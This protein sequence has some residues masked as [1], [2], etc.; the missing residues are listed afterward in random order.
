MERDTLS[1]RQLMALLWGALL[2]PAAQLLPGAGG[3]YG[4]RGALMIFAAGGVLALSGCLC[5]ALCRGGLAKGL[6][7]TM[8][9]WLGTALL[10][11]YIIWLEVLL[12]LWLRQSA[13]RLMGAGERDGA[14]WF[15]L[16]VLAGMAL[17]M[18]RRELGTLGRTAQIL[19]CALVVC[20]GGVLL[21]ALGQ[22]RSENLLPMQAWSI[23]AGIGAGMPGLE[24]VGYGLFAPFLLGEENRAP[25]RSW[26]RW[27]LVWCGALALMQTVVV[28]CFGG[29][30][31]RRLPAPFFQLAKSVGV[32]GAFQRIESVVS[33]VWAFADLLL[34]SALLWAQGEIGR[35]LWPNSPPGSTPAA[36]ALTAGAA[37][38]ALFSPNL[39]RWAGISAL[40]PFGGLLL[41]VFVPL[42][43][44][45]IKR[46]GGT[47]GK[48]G[49]SCVSKQG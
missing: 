44:Y 40:L 7:E 8:P 28:G 29:A 22:V 19:L 39:A 47:K 10:Y 37:A 26:I 36:A 42:S 48:N 45:L 41:G 33:A 23:E 35:V 38:L 18:S 43:A 6:K 17:W 20:G 5:A 2:A 15:F 46:G 25:A 3:E 49:T 30:L 21:L 4:V 27:V 13:R 12:I 16:V 11:L 34:L 1:F 14:A 24:M 31:T 32:E 9:G